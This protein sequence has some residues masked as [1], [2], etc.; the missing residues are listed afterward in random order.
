MG[1][2]VPIHDDPNGDGGL[3]TYNN[4]DFYTSLGV[5]PN[6]P[7]GIID[8]NHGQVTNTGSAGTLTNGLPANTPTPLTGDTTS[9]GG[10]SGSGAAGTGTGSGG[11]LSGLSGIGEWIERSFILLIGLL[12]LV[13]ALVWLMRRNV[14]NTARRSFN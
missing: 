7:L 9:A 3:T 12:F 2:P 6:S 11:I 5:T 13:V 14:S 10:N 8:V 1:A 4:A